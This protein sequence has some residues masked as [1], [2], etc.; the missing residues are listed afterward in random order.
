MGARLNSVLRSGG[1]PLG[2]WALKA[3][4]KTWPE[5]V[6]LPPDPHNVTLMRRPETPRFERLSAASVPTAVRVSDP[7]IAYSWATE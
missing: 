5:T 4:T 6:L 2:R 3:L 7:K 1:S